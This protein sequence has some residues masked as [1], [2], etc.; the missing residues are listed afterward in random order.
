MGLFKTEEE[1]EQKKQEKEQKL[2]AKY[3]LDQLTDQ[4]DIESVRNIAS[5]LAGT[6]LMELG[7][8]L[9]F[10]AKAEDLIQISCQKAMVEQNFMIIRKLCEISE[11]L[12]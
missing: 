8:T 1:K 4:K 5:E 6:G 7:T 9:S 11:K 3:G 10:G 2:L 12:K